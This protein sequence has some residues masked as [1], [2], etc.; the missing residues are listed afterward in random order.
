MTSMDRASA[1]AGPEA[2]RLPASA[3]MAGPASA[4]DARAVRKRRRVM[5]RP[6]RPGGL[7]QDVHPDF[8]HGD[9]AQPGLHG[10]KA[11]GEAGL[12]DLAGFKGNALAFQCQGQPGENIG[13]GLCP[14][15]RQ[16]FMKADEDASGLQGMQHPA[17]KGLEV[18][19]IEAVVAGPDG[20]LPESKETRVRRRG[21]S[22]T[23]SAMPAFFRASR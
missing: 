18:L 23:Q 22:V 13:F 5:P 16:A 7:A 19:G 3:A 6:P 2:R 20:A 1:P 8:P 15:V 10:G 14:L 4:S 12:G 11:G 9:V 21:K 17:S